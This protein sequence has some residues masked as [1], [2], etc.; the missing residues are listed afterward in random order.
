MSSTLKNMT[1]FGVDCNDIML[2][3]LISAA[4][5]VLIPGVGPFLALL[6]V[7]GISWFAGEYGVELAYIVAVSQYAM[8]IL[9]LLIYFLFHV[10]GAIFE[11]FGDFLSGLSF[12]RRTV[13]GST[14]T[15]QY[16]SQPTPPEPEPEPEP[17]FDF[18]I[19]PLTLYH[20]T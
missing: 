7:L 20:G 3:G 15:G 2:L 10:T 1:L 14:S 11:G 9:P 12:S 19:Q 8:V 18:K 4:P 13:S 17:E 16:V 6:V 5:W